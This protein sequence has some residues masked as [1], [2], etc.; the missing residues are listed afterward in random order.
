M[1]T[2]GGEELQLHEF[3]I[4][5]LDGGECS[6]SRTAALC[7]ERVFGTHW[8]GGSVSPRAGSDAVARRRYPSPYRESS[9]GRPAH[10]L[11]TILTELPQLLRVPQKLNETRKIP[12]SLR[13]T[14]WVLKHVGCGIYMLDQMER[15]K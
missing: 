1:K 15:H 11:V 13:D 7:P 10:I 12:I 2:Y 6:A 3:L 14:V 4:S 8:L 9:P 5:V